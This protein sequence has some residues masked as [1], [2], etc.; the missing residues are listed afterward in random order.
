M[1]DW[2]LKLN[3][4]LSFYHQIT[5]VKN[6]WKNPCMN[7]QITDHHFNIIL[8]KY[9][10]KNKTWKIFLGCQSLGV[11]SLPEFGLHFYIL[12]HYQKIRCIVKSLITT[13]TY[14]LLKYNQKNK[15]WK[16]LFGCQSLG[17]EFPRVW[18]AF[19]HSKPFANN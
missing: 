5:V 11:Q 1:E 12:N 15:T 4:W 16:M 2:V 13:S 8:L 18:S 3:W 17:G 7:S 9:N 6:A 19:L 10:W 14:F